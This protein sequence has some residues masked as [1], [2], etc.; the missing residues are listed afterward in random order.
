MS[1]LSGIWNNWIVPLSEIWPIRHIS[2]VFASLICHFLKAQD[3]EM[4]DIERLCNFT[5]E[6]RMMV[7]DLRAP[8]KPLFTFREPEKRFH[9]TVELCWERKNSKARLS[10]HTITVSLWKALGW[11]STHWTACCLAAF[12]EKNV[13]FFFFFFFLLFTLCLGLPF[14]PL[15]LDKLR[16]KAVWLSNGC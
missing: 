4:N 8:R 6:K 5:Q 15:F 12:K 11:N 3:T 9:S 1:N 16:W 13:W 14:L 2:Y 7:G 10:F